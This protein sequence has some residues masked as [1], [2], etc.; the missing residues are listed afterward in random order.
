LEFYDQLSSEYAARAAQMPRGRW[1]NRFLF[2][3]STSLAV[4]RP[5]RA[6]LAA[7]VPVLLSSSD[8]LF[9]PQTAFSR[10]RVQAVFGEAVAGA[11]DAPDPE[12]GA[13]LGRLLY[14]LQLAVILWW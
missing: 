13:A 4:L 7:L 3:L 14:L 11:T 6:A 8:G 9:A 2:A 10:Q 1:R 5:H 12:L